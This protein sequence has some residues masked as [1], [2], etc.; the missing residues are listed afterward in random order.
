VCGPATIVSVAGT[1]GVTDVSALEAELRER[2]E[3]LVN[4]DEPLRDFQAWFVPSFWDESDLSESTRRLADEVELVISEYTSGA[5]TWDEAT[6]L[7]RGLLGAPVVEAQWGGGFPRLV[8]GTTSILI[9]RS[10]VPEGQE[11]VDLQPA[12]IRYAAVRG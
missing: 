3:R 5:W 8:T 9:M 12:D 11:A 2:L 4:G 6:K 10:R 1:G 7:L